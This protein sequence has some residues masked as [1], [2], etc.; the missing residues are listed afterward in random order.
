MSAPIAAATIPASES[1]SPTSTLWSAM[2]REAFAMRMASGSGARLSTRRTTSA[3]SAA[4]AAPRAP[5]ATPRSA[6]A[7]AGAS[8]IPSP[9]IITGPRRRSSMTTF[10]LSAG[11]RSAAT[12]SMGSPR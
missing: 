3:A 11:S 9:T 12:A 2:A 5:K 8:L 6:A 7:S 4:A 1:P 10:V